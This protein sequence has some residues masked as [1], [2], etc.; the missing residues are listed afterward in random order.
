MSSYER[1]ESDVT[2]CLVCSSG[3][4]VEKRTE[5]G[6]LTIFGR[7]G[8][9]TALH[10][11]KRCNFRN[12]GFSCGAGYF[13]GY[14]TFKGTKYFDKYCLTNKVLNVTYQTGF[15]IDYLVETVGRV[16]ISSSTFEGLTKEFNRFHCPKLPYDVL[17]YR[18]ELHIERLVEAYSLYSFLEYSQRNSIKDWYVFNCSLEDK[19]MSCKTEL[20]NKFRET[21]TVGHSCDTPGCR[22]ALVIDGGL[23]PHRMICGAKTSGVRVFKGAEVSIVTGCPNI[24]L[25]NSKFCSEHESSEQ[26]AIP[27]VKLCEN[28]KRKLLG[29]SAGPNPKLAGQKNLLFNK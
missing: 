6:L 5:K 11:E 1:L 7:N 28:N 14:M 4:V 9:R 16:Q 3:T 13:H 20:F 19:I 23:K 18:S 24:P 27:G 8:P 15:D 17:N 22:I 25:P 2:K 21:W 10:V 26:P 29:A 12:G